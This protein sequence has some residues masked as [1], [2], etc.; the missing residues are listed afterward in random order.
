MIVLKDVITQGTRVSSTP[1]GIKD[2]KSTWKFSTDFPVAVDRGISTENLKFYGGDRDWLL[3]IF[4][5]DGAN[6]NVEMELQIGDEKATLYLDF[7]EVSFNDVFFE[8]GYKFSLLA[9]R[10]KDLDATGKTQVEETDLLEFY[11][12]TDIEVT[13]EQS[14]IK[15]L[16][17]EVFCI[18]K[19]TIAGQKELITQLGNFN[20]IGLEATP[21]VTIGKTIGTIFAQHNPVS[22]QV[23][24]TTT[25][26]VQFNGGFSSLLSWT[27]PDGS[28]EQ[29][30]T[31]HIKGRWNFEWV[32]DNSASNITSV[33][34]FGVFAYYTKRGGTNTLRY[35]GGFSKYESGARLDCTVDDDIGFPVALPRLYNGVDYDNVEVHFVLIPFITADLAAGLATYKD[36]SLSS[37]LVTGVKITH[38]VSNIT[39]NARF[40]P[41]N[42]YFDLLGTFDNQCRQ[43]LESALLTSLPLMY[44]NSDL[45]EVKPSDVMH[46]VSILYAVKF[47]ERSGIYAVLPLE[48]KSEEIWEIGEFTEEHFTATNNY[49][50]FKKETKNSGESS[51]KY[52]EQIFNG[53]ASIQQTGRQSN[54]LELN[55][56]LT[57][58]GNMILQ[59]L[60]KGDDAGV[61]MFHAADFDSRMICQTGSGRQIN[62]FYM[63]AAIVQRLLPFFSSFLKPHEPLFVS[64]CD[65]YFNNLTQSGSTDTIFPPQEMFYHALFSAKI[66]LQYKTITKLLN[67]CKRLKIGG[68]TITLTSIEFNIE[69][70][71]AEISGLLEID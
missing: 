59:S 34:W 64:D 40:L 20:N 9:D 5:R 57:T 30:K 56:T 39:R 63:F 2:I 24:G 50:G 67:G 70:N 53:N 28:S 43:R 6:A 54:L 12:N 36:V 7:S 17:A 14:E 48:E 22:S 69:P 3:T 23:V 45:L 4:E 29:Y 51:F 27:P 71:V 44:G 55:T 19:T 68:K 62:E 8:V 26:S 42:R 1:I 41:V 49:T 18:T 52:N 60:I 66:P 16:G 13:T 61:M 47:E 32:L 15:T 25:C 31:A 10:I 65:P 33:G 46:D 21:N 38:S 11:I 35:L 37:C 58:D